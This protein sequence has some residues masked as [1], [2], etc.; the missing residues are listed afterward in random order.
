MFNL[1]SGAAC[2]CACLCEGGVLATVA[3]ATEKNRRML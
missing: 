2:A 3:A 1:A